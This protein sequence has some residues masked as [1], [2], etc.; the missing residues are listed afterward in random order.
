[1]SQSG[2]DD[3]EDPFSP[4]E[5]SIIPGEQSIGDVASGSGGSCGSSGRHGGS[6]G[7]GSGS[8]KDSP[9]EEQNTREATRAA[10]RNS[11]YARGMQ[12]DSQVFYDTPPNGQAFSAYGGME[13]YPAS[14]EDGADQD[15]YSNEV[16][17]SEENGAGQDSYSNGVSEDDGAEQEDGYNYNERFLLLPSQGGSPSDPPSG[18]E[19]AGNEDTFAGRLSVALQETADNATPST[20]DVEIADSQ[21]DSDDLDNT[22]NRAASWSDVEVADSQADPEDLNNDVNGAASSSDREVADSQ[23]DSDSL[24]VSSDDSD[25]EADTIV[26][27]QYLGRG[28]RGRLAPVNPSNYHSYGTP[29]FSWPHAGRVQGTARGRLAPVHVPIHLRNNG[30]PDG[31]P[32]SSSSDHNS[33]SSLSSLEV[34][35][36]PVDPELVR[37]E[38]EYKLRTLKICTCLGWCTCT[39][40]NEGEN[41]GS[42]VLA[43]QTHLSESALQNEGFPVSAMRST[44]A[45]EERYEERPVETFSWDRR[46][47]PVL[48]P[49][50]WAGGEW[51]E[52]PGNYKPASVEEVSD[53]GD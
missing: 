44:I 31:D 36:E 11:L 23:A 50:S 7:S 53:A 29:N 22:A 5:Q 14:E 42:R 9:G 51:T 17:E 33:E 32:D 30:D 20:S 40:Y 6:S 13:S 2:S 1:M 10:F 27:H 16:S 12:N 49:V 48:A 45:A 37:L 46:R 39:R 34:T 28:N 24:V 41:A 25:S 43:S 19:Y 26:V 15:G 8:S 18:S 52:F 47:R 35:P 21:A 38:R 4:G 3:S